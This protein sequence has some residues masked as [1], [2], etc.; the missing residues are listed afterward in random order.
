MIQ[1]N[2]TARLT[3]AKTTGLINKLKTA[4]KKAGYTVETTH[5]DNW[6]AYKADEPKN[7]TAIKKVAEGLGW[8]WD[9]DAKGFVCDDNHSLTLYAAYMRKHGQL[10][11]STVYFEPG[12]E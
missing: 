8:E 4:L 11:K 12:Y 6:S 5:G 1:L 2:A 10:D 9:E 3:A 7:L